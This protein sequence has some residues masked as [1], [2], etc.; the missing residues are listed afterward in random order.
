MIPQVEHIIE[1]LA[2]TM[3]VFDV[4]TM[5]QALDTLNGLLLFQVG[6][7]LAAALGLLGL[8]LAVVGVYGVISYSASQRTHEIGIRMAIG[9][10]PMQIL[11]MVFRQGLLIIVIG[12]A[13]GIVAAFASARVLKGFLVVSATDPTTYVTV[14]VAL[15]LVALSACYIPA[16]RAAKVEPMVALRCE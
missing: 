8:V 10:E 16:R 3:P 6:A 14:A 7:G 15:T 13:V 9:A 5:I 11:R 4:Q 12:L 2:P 1:S